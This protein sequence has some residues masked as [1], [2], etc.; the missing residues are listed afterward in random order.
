MDIILQWIDLIWLP[1]MMFVVPK[2]RRLMVAGLFLSCALMMRMQIE[3]ME[4]TGYETGFM[5]LIKSHV[6]NRAI[7][8]YNVFYLL[9]V[10]FALL[11]SGAKSVVFM[12]ASISI[13][14]MAMLTSMVVMML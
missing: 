1:V 8:V 10:G 14:F 6:Q 4:Y 5:P 3:L 12:A 11:T 2:E 9:Y 7:G 13:F